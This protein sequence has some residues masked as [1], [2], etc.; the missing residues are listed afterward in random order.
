[1]HRDSEKIRANPGALHQSGILT[2]EPTLTRAHARDAETGRA[3]AGVKT[4]RS[5][6]VMLQ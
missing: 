1:M 6:T 4:R 2:T 3:S 5:E